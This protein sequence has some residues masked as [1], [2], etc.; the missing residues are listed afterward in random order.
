MNQSI[1]QISKEELRT[2]LIMGCHLHK[3]QGQGKEGIRKVIREQGLVQLD[4]LAPCARYHDYFFSCR[5]PDYHQGE[6]EQLAYPEKL[7]FET[8]FH[9][10][11]AISMEYFP[12]FYSTTLD[13]DHLGRYY[14]RALKILEETHPAML[15][16]VLEYIKSH[17][18]TQGSDLA[19]LGKADPK[20]AVW[21]T[22]RNSGTALELLW[23]M[24]KLA[25]T[26]DDKFRKTYDLIERYVD[27]T[28]LI[29][30]SLSEEKLQALKLKLKLHSFPVIS[31]GRIS[32][33]KKEKMRFRKKVG[34]DPDK[35]LESEESSEISL[36]QLND[37]SGYIVPSN[38]RDLCQEPLDNEM[39]IIGP[40]DPL[41]WDRQLLKLF[42]FDYVWE[43]YKRPKDRVWG[44][45]VYPILYEGSFIGRLEAKFDSKKK[46]LRVFNFQ[47]E[48]SFSLNQGVREASMRLMTRWKA[49]LGAEKIDYDETIPFDKF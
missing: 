14:G 35:L 39:R 12:L 36:V 17:G 10:L 46:I 30:K 27:K 45:Y 7:V 26:R 2:L 11:N 8:Y 22:N 9:N 4:P 18:P 28:L 41:I 24:G 25:V 16:Q 32:N 3:W 1:P 33:S 23:A 20:Y 21:K 38:W 5:I 44:Y 15:E 48:K 19:K 47:A 31:T 49:M 43:V 42:D 6:F 40:L 34:I 13:R 29:K 37:T